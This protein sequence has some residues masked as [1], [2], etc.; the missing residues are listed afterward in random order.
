[1]IRIRTGTAEDVERINGFYASCGSSA[2]VDPGETVLV[3]EEGD[4]MVG[5]VRLCT[6]RGHLVL[7]TML[8]QKDR[9]GEGIGRRMLLALE[10]LIRDRD[11]YCL[12]FDRLVDFYGGIGFVQIPAYQAPPHLQERRRRYLEKGEKILVMKRAAG[13]KGT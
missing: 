9:R 2:K 10:G 13:G 4:A 8:V 6:E 7:R 1:M 12:P 5:A 11:C 3:A